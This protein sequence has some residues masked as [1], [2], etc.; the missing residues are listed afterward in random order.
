MSVPVM[1]ADRLSA[2]L[3]GAGLDLLLVSAPANVRWLT[4][5]T[6]SSGVAVVGADGTRRFVTDF[7]YAEQSAAQLDPIWVR[8]IASGDLLGADLG[9]AATEPT[10]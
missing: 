6:G 8:R 10:I 7:R 1:R 4:G 9:G 5:F 3:A 2:A